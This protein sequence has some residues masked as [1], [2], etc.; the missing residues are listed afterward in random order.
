MNPTILLAADNPLGHVVDK[1]LLSTADGT[2]I[3]TMHM[4]TLLAAALIAFAVLWQAGR[5]IETGQESE[6]PD[7][8][9]TRGRVPQVVEVICLYLRE[10]V[11]R[12]QLGDATDK[13]I[14][15]L[16]ATFFFI[17]LNNLFGLVPLMDLQH[18]IGALGWNDSHFSVIGGTATGNIAITAALALVAFVIVQMHGLKSNG[19]GGYL[20]HFMGGAPVGLAPIMVPVEI[21]GTFIKPFALAIRLFANMVAGH[22][23][24]A[25]LLMFTKMA[26]EGVGVFG[27]APITLVAVVSAVP[28]MFLEV[29]VAF[30]QAFVFMFLVTVF[31]AQLSHHDHGDHAH[32]HGHG[33]EPA[34]AG[35][36]H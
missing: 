31:I 11:V 6:G 18:L 35:V 2:P 24:L 28:I 16:W 22:T 19:L 10:K 34:P 7:R 21:L 36:S 33:H 26:L 27:G 9:L 12:P 23:L 29:F 25:T 4:V 5:R 15:Y 14:P 30:L 3:L 32:D 8:Y 13:Y 17:L 1:V 20:K